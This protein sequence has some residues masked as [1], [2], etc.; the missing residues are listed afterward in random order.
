MS[1]E[2]ASGDKTLSNTSASQSDRSLFMSSMVRPSVR[3]V[4]AGS[5]VQEVLLSIEKLA[6]TRPTTPL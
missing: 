3:N 4:S 1:V 5:R 2:R 6:G